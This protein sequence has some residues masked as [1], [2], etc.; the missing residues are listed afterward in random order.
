MAE[1]VAGKTTKRTWAHKS[2][3]SG[4]VDPGS[5]KSVDADKL[6]KT[7]KLLDGAIALAWRDVMTNR[8]PP[9]LTST[10]WVWRLAGSYH[11]THSYPPLIKKAAQHFAKTGRT[12]LAQWA[13]QK[14]KEE[15]GHDLLTLQDIQSMGYKASALVEAVVHP[16]AVALV[17]Y[18]TQTVKSPDPI[19]CVGYSYTMERLATGIGTKKYIQSVETMLPQDTNAT[20]CLRVH[21]S[22]GAD[23]EH[24]EETVEMVAGL[25]PSER[26]DIANACYKT[27]L[28]CFNPPKE[29]YISDEELHHVLKP[30]KHI[31]TTGE[32]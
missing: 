21:S 22:V 27:A 28:L 24:V 23:V 10:R 17:N 15:Q 5:R 16:G 7:R 19:G 3:S 1:Q 30:L 6:A 26:N 32:T 31:K 8:R 29:G 12:S 4:I 20:R 11:L 9:A 14:A 2:N 18:F 13:E 25:S